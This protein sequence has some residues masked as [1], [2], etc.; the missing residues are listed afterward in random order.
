MITL[1][2]QSHSKMVFLFFAIYLLIGVSIFRDY[3]ISCDETFQRDIG[4]QAFQFIIE[5]NQ[6]SLFYP[7]KYYGPVLEVVLISLEK[8]LRGIT[9]ELRDVFYMRHLVTFLLFYLGTIFFYLLCRERFQS[10][11][12]GLLG[13]F[14]LI[15]SP[16]IFADSFYNSKDIAFLSVFIISVYTLT[17]YLNQRTF[18]RALIHALVSAFLIDIR[19]PGIIVPFFTIFSLILLSFTADLKVLRENLLSLLFYGAAL[20]LFT[21]F[22]WPFLWFNSIGNF[23]SA[24]KFMAHF[25][26]DY[27]LLYGGQF[28]YASAVP[29]HYIPVW[30]AITT[31]IAYIVLFCIGF[32][33]LWKDLLTQGLSFFQKR[34]NDFIFLIWF[35][36]PLVMVI[37]LKSVLYDAWRQMFFVYPA[38]LLLS[39][40]GLRTL[41]KGIEDR[42]LAAGKVIVIVL[43]SVNLMN[44]AYFM[45]KNHPYQNVYFNAFAGR[46]MADVKD[47][48]ELDYWG[49]SYRKALEYIVEHDSSKEIRV[50]VDFIPGVLNSIMLN[51]QDSRRLKYV[52]NINK[53]KYFVGNYK[54]H[55]K[56]YLF[57]KEFYST[58]VNGVKIV[59]VYQL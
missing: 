7:G 24:F 6:G 25:P 52:N 59:C 8:V 15:L 12:M 19:I 5:P 9:Q 34:I 38:F 41:L 31:P 48:F 53:A 57:K 18:L 4:Q 55:R 14:F 36:F 35:L 22:L 32:A 47:N 45:I 20:I 1:F 42:K 58:K 13:S 11:K 17:S 39:L 49:L 27:K 54:W 23:W 40:I 33:A 51:A 3:G 2:K 28:L 56:E 26:I 29:W 50:Y 43:L 46:D 30:I 16:R 10:W 21:I 37:V 44:V